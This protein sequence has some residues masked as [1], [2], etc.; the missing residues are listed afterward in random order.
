[1]RSM[2]AGS[3]S[4]PLETSIGPVIRL[5][6]SLIYWDCYHLWP[7]TPVLP[8]SHC[9]S[10]ILPLLSLTLLPV[11]LKA[12]TSFV[13][14]PNDHVQHEISR[15]QNSQWLPH[16]QMYSSLRD[17]PEI[18]LHW[19]PTLVPVL[20]PLFFQHIWDFCLLPLPALSPSLCLACL[21]CLEWHFPHFCLLKWLSLK[22]KFK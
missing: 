15:F 3:A 14:G 21:F 8:T 9:K 5:F 19:H 16:G 18:Y 4:S 7:P 12:L 20:I 10:G 22:L 17:L 13:L 6:N 1:M 2:H 11:G